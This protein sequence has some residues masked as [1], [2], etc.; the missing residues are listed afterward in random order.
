VVIGNFDGVH[1]GHQAVLASALS[2]SE[3]RALG[4]KVLT[5]NP[6]P[7]EVLGRGSRPVLTPI[8]RKVELLRRLGP[9]LEVIVKPFTPELARRTPDEF[10]SGVLVEELFAKVVIVGENFRFGHDRKGD[11]GV[12]RQLGA[13]YGFE[14]RAEQLV[15]DEEGLFSST[16][17]RDALERGDLAGVTRCLGRPHAISGTV[18]KG[19]QRG[20]SL[21]FPTANLASV[22]EAIPPYGVYA[23]LVDR[24]DESGAKALARG[25]MNLGV[26][27]TLDAGYSAEVHLLDYEADLYGASLRLHL[28]ERLRAEQR[29]PNLEALVDQIGRDAA[30][31]RTLLER[32]S[33][34]L[35]ANGAWA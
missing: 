2:L 6:H 23:C 22:R 35:R 24:V 7:A 20:R 25:V 32:A 28:V 9:E 19:A 5:F 12:L 33:P 3:N 17:A 31:A 11:L 26:R 18:I 4:P 21:G 13:K 16:R 34:D 30:T 10:V 29:F 15:G 27:P 14:V 8:D 1:R